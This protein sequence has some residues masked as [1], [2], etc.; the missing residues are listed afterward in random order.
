M[1]KKERKAMDAQSTTLLFSPH[2][3][4]KVEE[5]FSLFEKGKVKGQRKQKNQL[6]LPDCKKCNWQFLHNLSENQ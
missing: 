5:I 4:D 1:D 6:G 2:V 3:W